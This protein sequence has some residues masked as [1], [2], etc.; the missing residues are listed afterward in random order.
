MLVKFHKSFNQAQYDAATK[1]PGTLYFVSDTKRLYLGADLWSETVEIVSALP[2]TGTANTLYVVETATNIQLSLGTGTAAYK[3]LAAVPAG[4][5]VTDVTFNSTTQ[6]FTFTFSDAT[7]K[8]VDLVLETVFSNINYNTT[9]QALDLTKVDGT[10]V[11]VPISG[12]LGAAI[13]KTVASGTSGYMVAELT[14]TLNATNDALTI[15]KTHVSVDGDPTQVYDL[16]IKAGANI[17]M[18]PGG[19]PQAPEIVISSTGGSALSWE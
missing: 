4:V 5:V 10:V 11:S 9:T 14:A 17:T 2:A 16:I 12:L 15:R 13:P 1:D 19:T 8:T 18:T 3:P 6:E 7:T